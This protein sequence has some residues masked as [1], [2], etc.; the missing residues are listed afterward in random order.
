MRLKNG[1]EIDLY[2]NQ[3]DDTYE[4][5]DKWIKVNHYLVVEIED[6]DGTQF[7]KD[8][9]F[10]S[11]SKNECIN[12]MKRLLNDSTIKRSYLYEKYKIM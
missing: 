5:T 7:I 1:N 4:G 3:K 11:E 9:L 6:E 2:F 12:E 8:T 10:R